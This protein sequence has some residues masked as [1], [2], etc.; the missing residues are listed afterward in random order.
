MD[1]SKAIIPAA[2]LGT[3]LLP[4]TKSIPKEMMPL[5]TKPAIHYILEEGI[6]SGIKEYAIVTSAGKHSLQDYFDH[7]PALEH[8]LKTRNK[9][10]AVAE[11]DRIIR[12]VSLMYV[13]QPEPLGVADAIWRARH[14]IGKE[15]FGVMFPDDII[16]G[17]ESGLDQLIRIARQEKGSVIAVQEVPMEYIGSYGVVEVKKNLT[18][19]LF[20][21]ST[22]VEKPAVKDAPSNL[23]IVGRYVLS[24]KIFPAIEEISGYALETEIGLTDAI[25]AMIRSGEKVFAYKLH[26]RRYDIGTPLGWLKGVIG[27]ALEDPIYG[28]HVQKIVQELNTPESFLYNPSKAIE[29]DM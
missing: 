19:N 23:A 22:L 17:K 16:I 27:M 25:G 10:E 26:G 8:Y 18:Q 12:A 13:R 6:K 2:G 28:P 1:I 9:M 20:Q 21:I 7:D 5:L 3:R 11:I 24:H 4:F 29:H 15:Y 14:M